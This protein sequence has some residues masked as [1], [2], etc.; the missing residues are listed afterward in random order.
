MW[1]EYT[2]YSNMYDN[3]FFKYKPLQYALQYIKYGV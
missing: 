2:M 1:S 3:N